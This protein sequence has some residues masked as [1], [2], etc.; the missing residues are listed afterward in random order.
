MTT[1]TALVILGNLLSVLAFG[2]IGSKLVR[3][4]MRHRRAPELVLGLGLL[5]LV[6]GL[7]LLA[8]SGMGRV[9]VGE[10]RQLPLIAGLLSLTA[11]VALQSAFVWRTFR[12]DRH[13]A[14]GLCVA[15][16]AAELCVAASI[17]HA[18]Q[19][20]PPDLPATIATRDAVSWLR[21][22]MTVSYVWIAIEGSLQFRMSRR[23]EAL[24]LGNPVITNRFALWGFTGA[25]GA[26]NT[27]VSTVLHLNGMT[28]FA[29][30]AGAACLGIGSSIASIALFLTFLPPSR[31]VAW[32]RSPS[33]A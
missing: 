12:P 20:S 6:L 21:V 11:S 8:A 19:T 22:P 3:L 2:V 10:V 18:I 7:P 27:I 15:L 30:P 9:T 26:S 25:L 1:T 5:L 28:P 31:Y 13:W 32:V 4:A 24:G 23:R 17:V 14:L 29:H 16:G 33:G